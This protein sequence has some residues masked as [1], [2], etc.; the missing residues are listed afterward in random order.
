MNKVY[1]S[2]FSM[3]ASIQTG[4]NKSVVVSVRSGEDGDKSEQK[5]HHHGSSAGHDDR[6]L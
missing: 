3:Q 5:K 2:Q 6:S 1:V 4:N